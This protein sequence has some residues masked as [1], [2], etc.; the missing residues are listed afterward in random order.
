MTMIYD[1]IA[2]VKLVQKLLVGNYYGYLRENISI[3]ICTNC[4]CYS[5]CELSTNVQNVYTLCTNM[6]VPNGR[7]SGDGSSQAHRH[8]GHSGQLPPNLFVPHKFCCVQKNMFQTY[9]K[10][11]HISP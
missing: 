1:P 4:K 5:C 10:N 2:F 3:V 6:R 11:K 9:D 8:G 7:L